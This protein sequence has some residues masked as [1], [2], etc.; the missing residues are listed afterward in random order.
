MNKVELHVHLDGS[1]NFEYMS[2]LIGEDSHAIVVSDSSGDLTEYLSKFDI[3]CRLLQKRE[4]I[5]TFSRLLAEDLKKDGV[6]YAEVRFCPLFHT[7]YLSPSEVIEAVLEG[8]SNVDD[9]KINLILCMMRQFPMPKNLE[10]VNLYKKY[11]D[12][13]VVALDLAGDESRYKTATYRQLFEIIKLDNI[14]FVIHAGEAD[15]PES[16]NLAIEY[17]AKRIG[18]G[19]RS[20]ESEEVV[21]KLVDNNILL[22]LCPTSNLDTHAIKNLDYFPIKDLMTAG[23]KVCINTDNRSISDTTLE[24]EY[25]IVKENFDLT[26]EELLEFNLNAIEASFLSNQE[27]IMLKNKLIGKRNV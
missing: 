2:E 19:I 6:L 14:P 15:G 21:Q 10:I 24:K 27:K 11:C 18:H 3:P 1:L 20:I 22:E 7:A 5:V 8:I 16:V 17:G 4:N 12:K 23:V 13:G 9:I 26:D 25:Q